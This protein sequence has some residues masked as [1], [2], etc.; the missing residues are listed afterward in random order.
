M[1]NMKN[2]E[3]KTNITLDKDG[4]RCMYEDWQDVGKDIIAMETGKSKEV[5]DILDRFGKILSSQSWLSYISEEQLVSLIGSIFGYEVIVKTKTVEPNSKL[6]S[7]KV[8][9]AEDIFG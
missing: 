4:Y 6:I 2:V 7:I 1:E 3:T 8:S 5:D 9:L